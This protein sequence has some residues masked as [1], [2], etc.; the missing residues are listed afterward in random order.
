[1]AATPATAAET[2]F[3]VRHAEKADKSEDPPL[4]KAGVARAEKLATMLRDSGI[5]AI[6]V[7]QYRRNAETAAP[8]AR[9]LN[10]TP[11]VVPSGD[12][13]A[14]VD[15]IKAEKGRVLVVGHVDTVPKILAALGAPTTLTLT[16]ADYDNLF[17]LAATTLVRLHF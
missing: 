13:A 6:F 2:V 5:R 14:L 12:V 17:V 3:L 11:Q 15:K 9:L 8:L 1:L 7:T 16:D 4:S 10:V